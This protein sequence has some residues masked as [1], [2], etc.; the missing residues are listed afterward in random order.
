MEELKNDEHVWLTT[1]GDTPPF[2]PHVALKRGKLCFSVSSLPNCSI[3][4]Q[5]GLPSSESAESDGPTHRIL[6]KTC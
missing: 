5:D 4:L 3:A 1:P 6:C 2:I